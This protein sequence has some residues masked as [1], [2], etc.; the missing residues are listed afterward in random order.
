MGTFVPT[1]ERFYAGGSTTVRGFEQY[2]LGPIGLDGKP[3]G[4]DALLILN[5]E[6]RFPLI[7]IVDGVTFLDVGNVFQRTKDFSFTDLRKGAGVGVRVRTK[8]VLVRGDYGFV[9]DPRAGEQR[10]RFY[11]SIGQAF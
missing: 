6:L 10:S 8:W 1:S 3:T 11:F 9:L 2:A 5:N 7:G 4:G